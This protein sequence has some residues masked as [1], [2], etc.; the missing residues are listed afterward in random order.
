M[1]LCDDAKAT[2]QGFTFGAVLVSCSPCI[3]SVSVS[4]S[5]GHR[6]GEGFTLR[7]LAR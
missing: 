2:G 7:A 1:R 5:Y 4:V 6:S 3:L